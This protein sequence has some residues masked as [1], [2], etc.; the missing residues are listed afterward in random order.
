M[1]IDTDCNKELEVVQK[2]LSKLY[3]DIADSYKKM[4]KLN[5]PYRMDMMQS[6]I[7]HT[8]K[9]AAEVRVKMHALQKIVIDSWK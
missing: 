2:Q 8:L 5:D 6:G 9:V 7:D 3:L 1:S 4:S